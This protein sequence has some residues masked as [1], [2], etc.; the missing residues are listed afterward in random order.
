MQQE[1]GELQEPYQSS[2][3]S[4]KRVSTDSALL[5]FSSLGTCEAD[6]LEEFLSGCT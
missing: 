6:I 1:A 5:E 2:K 3:V 4:T